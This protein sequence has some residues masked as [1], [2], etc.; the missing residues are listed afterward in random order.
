MVNAVLASADIQ[1]LRSVHS[2]EA[3]PAVIRRNQQKIH[4]TFVK[5]TYNVSHLSEEV[6]LDLHPT[7][8]FVSFFFLNKHYHGECSFCEP[9]AK[10]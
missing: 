3:K 8:V 7:V 10:G 2:S 5:L 1:F 6:S 9:E 4:F